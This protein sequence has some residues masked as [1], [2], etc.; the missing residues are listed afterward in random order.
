MITITRRAPILQMRS[1]RAILA[2]IQMELNTVLL[3]FDPS[4]V[5]RRQ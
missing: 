3:E 2:R 4:D 5:D 1:L